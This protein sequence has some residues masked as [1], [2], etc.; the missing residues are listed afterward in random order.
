MMGV[1]HATL[2]VAT[3]C[4]AAPLIVEATGNPINAGT[5][6]IGAIPVAGAALIPDIDHPNG[7]IANSGGAITRT[8][9]KGA[10]MLSGGHREGT[11]TLPFFAI[12]T[13]TAFL[14]V[15]AGNMWA[16]LTWY[17]VLS[18]FG[19]QALAKT[20]L[21]QTFNKKWKKNT[22]IFAK[23]Y[24]WAFAALTTGAATVV[25]GLNDPAAWWWLPWG[26][27]IGHATHLIGDIMT[28]AGLDLGI[29]LRRK[30]RFPI[31]GDA[32]SA[33]EAIFTALLSVVVV[34][35]IACAVLGVNPYENLGEFGQRL[36]DLFE[37]QKEPGRFVIK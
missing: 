17:F 21:H 5:L 22:G 37:T 14:T 11:H 30:V 18:A 34:F 16:A 1:G 33:R 7:S 4:I 2:G 26:V 10:A 13:A 3:W 15:W 12:V 23:A 9:A 31:L 28:T 8:I 35:F 19:A 25:Y 20:A 32:G 27:L 24:C 29:G 6:I 36:A